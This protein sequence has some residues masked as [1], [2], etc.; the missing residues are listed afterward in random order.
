MTDHVKNFQI[1]PLDRRHDRAHF[2]CRNSNLN[3]YLRKF[4]RQNDDNNISKTFVAIDKQ[5]V[6]KGYYCISTSEASFA[7]LPEAIKKSL[8][9]YPIPAALIGRLAIDKSVQGCGLGGRLLIDALVRIAGASEQIGIKVIV[10]DAIDEKAKEF[11]QHYGFEEVHDKPGKL[12]LAIETI[13]Q[14]L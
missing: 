13:K 10:V 2:N 1:E 9:Q 11:Y 12:V 4:A 6:I 7:E 14:L 8:P 3:E 5:N